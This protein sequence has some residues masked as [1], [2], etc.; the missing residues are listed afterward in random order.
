[1]PPML[2]PEETDNDRLQHGQHV[3]GCGIDFVFVEVGN[4]F[5][6]WNPSRQWL[7]QRRSSGFTMLGKTPHSRNGSTM[8]RPSSIAFRTFISAS[9]STLL[10]DVRAVMAK[11][12]RIGTPEVMSVPRVPG[13][14]GDSDLFQQD[15]NNRQPKQHGIE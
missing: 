5:A 12:S 4:F 15:A 11:P 13:K 14:T 7:R 3:F 1:M 10:P 8:V 9:S 2:T 6:A